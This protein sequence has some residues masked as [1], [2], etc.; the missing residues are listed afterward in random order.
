MSDSPPAPYNSY[1]EFFSGSSMARFRHCTRAGGR[2]PVRMLQVTQPAHE[3]EDA[4]TDELL[5]GLVLGGASSARW[6]WGGAGEWRR[7]DARRAGDIGVSPARTTGHFQVDGPSRM[8][9][10]GLPLKTLRDIAGPS[11][12]LEFGSLHDRY[13]QIPRAT[14]LCMAMWR[15]AACPG[16]VSDGLIEAS[17]AEL[18]DT[19][20]GFDRRTRSAQPHR[21]LSGSDMKTIADLVAACG[22]A[23]LSVHDLAAAVGLPVKSFRLRFRETT[24]QRPH[25]YL[26][27]SRL[28][29][30]QRK[31]S[32]TGQPIADIALELGFSSQAHLTM[33]F[34]RHIGISPASYRRARQG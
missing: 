32:G 30:A 2:W 10:V 31:L 34:T 33:A 19:L 13:A 22:P 17:A 16:S 3:D 29:S 8:L 6:S 23:D 18:I 26:V 20:Q 14:R 21:K 5:I 4:A 15:A 28:D 7:T 27:A 9:V 11:V 1:V 24:G 12:T 25:S